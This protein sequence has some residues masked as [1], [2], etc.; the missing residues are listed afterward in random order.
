MLSQKF[1]VDMVL[2]LDVYCTGDVMT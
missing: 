2:E 1:K